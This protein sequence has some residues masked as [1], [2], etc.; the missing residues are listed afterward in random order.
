M[1]FSK[2]THYLFEAQRIVF[3]F[4]PVFREKCFSNLKIHNILW[5]DKLHSLRWEDI[6]LIVSHNLVTESQL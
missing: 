6:N 5:E 2:A 3:I 4:F 1:L